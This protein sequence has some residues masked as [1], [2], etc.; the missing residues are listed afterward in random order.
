MEEVYGS[1]KYITT[2]WSEQVPELRLWQGWEHFCS[3]RNLHFQTF[4][5]RSSEREG[6]DILL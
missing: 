5:E 3:K 6:T 1:F 2:N 4:P